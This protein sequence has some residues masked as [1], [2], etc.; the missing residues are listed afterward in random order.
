[1]CDAFSFQPW[2]TAKIESP[3]ADGTL[4]ATTE[5]AGTEAFSIVPS[6]VMLHGGLGFSNELY[7]QAGL[8]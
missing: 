4:Q 3:L 2:R 1:M 6:Q 5:V 7:R 8:K